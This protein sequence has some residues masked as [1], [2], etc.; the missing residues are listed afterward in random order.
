VLD[1]AFALADELR[2]PDLAAILH[3]TAYRLEVPNARRH[4]EGWAT[5]ALGDATGIPEED[6]RHIENPAVRSKS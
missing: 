6:A 2:R 5:I 1:W 3:A 4:W